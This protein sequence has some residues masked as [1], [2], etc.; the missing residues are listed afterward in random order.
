MEMAG[1]ATDGALGDE[2]GKKA[3]VELE[4][5]KAGFGPEFSE[6]SENGQRGKTRRRWGVRFGANVGRETPHRTA[7]RKRSARG[8][9]ERRCAKL[10]C[11]R[12]IAKL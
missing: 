12:R 10:I 8:V 11:L 9:G 2:A 6:K 7:K 4:D 3:F 1:G 5:F